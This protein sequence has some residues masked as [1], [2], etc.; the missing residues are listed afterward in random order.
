MHAVRDYVLVDAN[1]DTVGRT[2]LGCASKIRNAETLSV[3]SEFEI[4]E[5]FRRGEAS[6]CDSDYRYLFH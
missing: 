4:N 3:S 6:D 5:L 1:A 2:L